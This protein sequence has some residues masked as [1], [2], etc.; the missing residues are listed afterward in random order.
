VYDLAR[1]PS[2]EVLSAGE[3]RSV[4]VWRGECSLSLSSCAL[5]AHR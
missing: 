3:D 4:R 1:T 2:G 5:A